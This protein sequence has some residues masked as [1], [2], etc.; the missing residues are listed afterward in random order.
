MCKKKKKEP[1]KP[2]KKSQQK[3][4]VVY[5]QFLKIIFVAGELLAQCAPLRQ[6]RLSRCKML[7]LFFGKAKL[8]AVQTSA[9]G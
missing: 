6:L 7:G 9:A 8:W 3:V 2:P 4:S 5:F 1:R